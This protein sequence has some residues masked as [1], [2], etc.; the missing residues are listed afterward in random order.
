MVVTTDDERKRPPPI[1]TGTDDRRFVLCTT[2]LLLSTM[3]SSLRG[4][5]ERPNSHYTTD[6]DIILASVETFENLMIDDLN[7]LLRPS[8]LCV[9]TLVLVRSGMVFNP[10]SKDLRHFILNPFGLIIS[11]IVQISQV[12][13]LV[14]HHFHCINNLITIH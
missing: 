8:A 9:C 2:L 3:C 7:Q 10:A 1:A 4:S 11:R 6:I 13:F 14:C 12:N 5:V